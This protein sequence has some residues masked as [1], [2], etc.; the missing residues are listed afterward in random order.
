MLKKADFQSQGKYLPIIFFLCILICCLVVC[1]AAEDIYQSSTMDTFSQ[2]TQLFAGT[3]DP[4]LDDLEQT[5]DFI[6]PVDLPHLIVATRLITLS[7]DPILH[8]IPSI[9]TL[10]HPPTII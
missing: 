10:L 4:G 1:F 6:H 9:R 7:Y 5:S 2:S 8:R 3:A